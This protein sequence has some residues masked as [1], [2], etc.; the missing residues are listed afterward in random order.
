VIEDVT[1]MDG[2][3]AIDSA[4]GMNSA[5]GMDAGRQWTVDGATAI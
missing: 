5:T 4:A 2:L 3:V 1:A